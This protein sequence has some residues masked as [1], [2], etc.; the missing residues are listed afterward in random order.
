[1]LGQSAMCA[2]FALNMTRR[3]TYCIH[4]NLGKTPADAMDAANQTGIAAGATVGT[5]LSVVTVD[6]VGGALAAGYVALEA[7]EAERF[8]QGKRG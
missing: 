1:M 8:S 3:V 7:S 2:A 4:R 6:P 5:L